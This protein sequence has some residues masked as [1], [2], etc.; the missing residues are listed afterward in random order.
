MKKDHILL[1][2]ANLMKNEKNNIFWIFSGKYGKMS[3]K[4]RNDEKRFDSDKKGQN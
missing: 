3:K 4:V 2:K 1:K